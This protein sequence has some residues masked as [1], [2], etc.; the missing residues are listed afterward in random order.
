MADA[1]D[2]E[3]LYTTLGVLPT[4]THADIVDSYKKEVELY[5]RACK[6][7]K[8]SKKYKEAEVR[9]REVSKAFVVLSDAPRRQ[10]YDNS[11]AVTVPTKVTTKSHKNSNGY[12]VNQNEQSITIFLPSNRAT[13]WITTC[14]EHHST[15]ATDRGKN[16]RHIKTVYSDAHSKQT[17]GSV[18]ITVYVSTD[19]ILVQGSAYLLWFLEE[20]PRLKEKVGAVCTS[21]RINNSVQLSVSASEVSSTPAAP[22]TDGPSSCPTCEQSIVADELCATCNTV[23]KALLDFN[24][25]AL[26]T[27]E[28]EPS[29]GTPQNL[30]DKGNQCTP[31]ISSVDYANVQDSVNKLESCLVESIADRKTSELSILQRLSVLEDRLKSG[32]R[33]HVCA[34]LSASEKRQLVEDIAR[35]DKVKC[36][37]ETQVKS[38][39]QKYNELSRAV[40]DA[41]SA[42]LRDQSKSM[43]TQTNQEASD[44]AER[45]LYELVNVN[46]HNRFQALEGDNNEIR[47]VNNETRNN[48]S[49]SSTRAKHREQTHKAGEKQPPIQNKVNPRPTVSTSQHNKDMP[50]DVL[51]LGDSNTKDS[52]DRCHVSR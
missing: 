46:V 25:N 19:K 9:H 15:K 31:P 6:L 44:R 38:L 51:I 23:P 49:V 1:S 43:E 45:L 52:Q 14:E 35:L 50:P 39:Q 47:E 30:A 34:G 42:S 33:N 48:S 2:R 40:H 24:S 7:G 4:A 29:E 13:T 11:G 8:K 17:V 18:S 5:E 32:E 3:E 21:E 37:L 28:E 26:C 36:E 12:S 20:F 41:Q 27:E 22:A 16:G 10:L